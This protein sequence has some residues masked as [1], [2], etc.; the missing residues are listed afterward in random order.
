MKAPEERATELW[1]EA[2]LRLRIAS[3]SDRELL[4]VGAAAPHGS[5]HLSKCWRERAATCTPCSCASERH[6]CLSISNCLAMA[7][8]TGQW[9]R[10]KRRCWPFPGFAA[11]NVEPGKS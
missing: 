7:L 8:L 4:R 3:S 2:L 11:P 9:N 5:G 6:T 10:R 1:G